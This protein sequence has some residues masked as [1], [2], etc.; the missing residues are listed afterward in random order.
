[1]ETVLLS[2]PNGRITSGKSQWE[3]QFWSSRQ[4]EK[5]M[6]AFRLKVYILKYI[7]EN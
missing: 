2:I 6:N 4:E 7:E 5:N 3:S 1:M